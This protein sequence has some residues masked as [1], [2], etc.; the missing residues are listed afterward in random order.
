MQW[1]HQK[2][3]EFVIGGI[4][5]KIIFYWT[6]YSRISLKFSFLAVEFRVQGL[7]HY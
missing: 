3:E 4:Q 5:S 6:P 2:S 7:Y 1:V